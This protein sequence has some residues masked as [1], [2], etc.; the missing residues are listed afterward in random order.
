[1]GFFVYLKLLELMVINRIN[2]HPMQIEI[3]GIERNKEENTPIIINHGYIS[4]PCN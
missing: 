4:E 3:H 1:M 2:T